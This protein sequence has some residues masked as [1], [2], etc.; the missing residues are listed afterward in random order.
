M[1]WAGVVG[2]VLLFGCRGGTP[3]QGDA[4]TWADVD[5]GLPDGAGGTDGSS[6]DASAP[7]A[8]A[9]VPDAGE[10]SDAGGPLNDA[11]TPDGGGAD[12]GVPD[13]GATDG[14]TTPRWPPPRLGYVNPIPAENARAGDANWRA[15]F[16]NP[17]AK[18]IE[19]YAD[20]VSASAG[21]TV[22][23]MVR[24][25]SSR[26]ASWALL[27]LGWYGGAGARVLTSGTT[28][29]SA[30]PAC[31][32][33]KG[34]GL[35]HCAWTPTFAVTIPRDAVS[36]LFLVRIVRSDNIG[37][38]IPVAVKDQRPADLFFQSSVTTAQAYN[39]WGGESLY[40][41]S[42]GITTGF[43]VM[44]SFDRPYTGSGSG[45]VLSYEAL[46]ARFLERYGYDVSY[47]T[48]LDVAREGV[49]ALLQRGAFLSVGHD[50]YWPTEE[51]PAVQAA[52]DQGVPLY[53]F[54][55][56]PAYWKVRL[57]SPGVDGNARIITCYK[58]HPSADP[59]YGTAQQT[60][61]YRDPPIN[62]PEEALT[63]TMYESWLLFGQPW[64]V[65]NAA[66]P[67]YAGTGL[68]DGDK[69][70]QLVGYEYDRP[71]GGGTPSPIT[72]VA[73]SPLVDAE[74]KPGYSEATIYTSPAFV[75]GAGTI[76]WARGLDEALRDPRVERMTANL[77]QLGL[78]LPVPDPL[79]NVS[80]TGMTGAN[81][82]WASSVGTVATGMPGPAGV[83]QLPDGS[84]V[85]ADPRVDRI[86]RVDASGAVAPYAGDGNPDGTRYDNVPGLQA[87][88]FGPTAVIADAAGNVYVSDTHECVIRKIGNDANHT[89]STAAG[90][91]M[92]CATVDGIGSIARFNSP[93]GLAWQDP[94]HL[95]IADSMSQAIRVLDVTTRLVTTLAV[96]HWGDDADGPASSANFYFPTAVAAAP[97][98]RVFF[99]ASSM[100]KLKVIGTD[101][102]RT[103]TT[104]VA[105]GLGF[106]DGSGSSAQMEPQAG[107]L[108]NNGSLLVSDSANQRLRLVTPGSNAA[109]TRVQTWAG[110]GQVGADDGPAAKASFQVPL[111]I[112]R[113]SGGWFYVV[114]GAAG[115]VRIVR[116]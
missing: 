21:E 101:A 27:R 59:F 36:G 105:G 64:A 110:S 11:G 35:V 56:N 26:T 13:G 112:A 18:Q 33:E 61:R 66:H 98:G 93:M 5:S 42:N 62:Q 67:M 96:T 111:G 74:G 54:G 34:T 68:R 53:F 17:F 38:L 114:D 30:Q 106:A 104:L 22:R 44:V 23:L 20:R 8:D 28:Q 94:S 76:Y 40:E 58:Q 52:R 46:M 51:R 1:R 43:A 48:N 91:M 70:P 69:I 31:L 82:A 37:V 2:L 88:F 10:P 55:A 50:E 72:V 102:A 75:F 9:G 78:S 71:F 14:G 90:A 57:S 16:T 39:D 89:V 115:T 49:S 87:R 45:Q 116:P 47:T 100:G 85:V 29:V 103:I 24:S 86:W 113:G 6:G 32:T 108:W 25:D 77:L 7:P 107:L 92:S 4:G 12:G 63:G 95:L 80:V 15:G 79:M 84:L 109:A 3:A 83:A 60:G 65:T 19:A 41:D 97:D 99:L 73:H 81:P